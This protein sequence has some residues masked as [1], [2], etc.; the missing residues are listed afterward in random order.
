MGKIKDITGMKFNKLTA[1]YIDGKFSDGS[2][3]W[4]CKCECGGEVTTTG[5]RLKRNLKV[6]CGCGTFEKLSKRHKSH[7]MAKTRFYKA[8]VS[9]KERCYRPYHVSHKSYYD[10]GITV[11]D[12]WLESFENFYEDMKDGYLDNLTLDR[13]NGNKNYCK[14]NCK[15]S[16]VTEQNN[17][18]R[19]NHIIEVDGIKDTVANTCRR[20]GVSYDRALYRLSK[21]WDADKAIKTPC[22]DKLKNLTYN[23]EAK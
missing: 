12:R 22:L 4:K 8:W 13:I 16:N 23:R 18:V 14:E 17:N 20:Y 21:G 6:D 11:C 1:L 3:L 2:S 10:K 9:M 19:T 7:G 5:T 15:W